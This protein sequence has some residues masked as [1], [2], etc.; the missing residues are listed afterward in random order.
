MIKFKLLNILLILLIFSELNSQLVKENLRDVVIT[1]SL[2]TIII[3]RAPGDWWFGPF[4]SFTPFTSLYFGKLRLPQFK[5]VEL[6]ELFKK[7]DYEGGSGW[8]YS[9][10]LY[11]EWKKLDQDFGAA[12]RISLIDLRTSKSQT[13][14]NDSVRT[15]FENKTEYSYLSV[16]PSAV[17]ELKKL[18]GFFA[19]GGFDFEIPLNAKTNQQK[20]FFYSEQI[21]EVYSM[22]LQSLNLRMGLHL[23]LSYDLF[24][25]NIQTLA[26]SQV[27]LYMLMN[28]GTN[29]ISNFGSNFNSFSVKMGVVIKIGP[30]RKFIDTL[31][32]NPD[33]EEPLFAMATGNYVGGINFQRSMQNFISSDLAYIEM[34]QIQTIVPVEPEIKPV[35]VVQVVPETKPTKQIVIG[36]R[37]RYNFPKSETDYEISKE[38]REYLDALAQFLI[39]N[40]NTRV[41]VEGH[42]DDRGGSVQENLR[43]S[44]LRAEQVKNYLM[45]KNIPGGRIIATGFGATRTLVPNNTAANRAK[46]RRVEIMVER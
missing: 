43:R 3:D 31:Y 17:Y 45:R 13:E 46:N 29:Q 12:L 16:S 38:L 15:I 24:S 27:S 32:F 44:V 1:N 19:F 21:D 26:R 37:E 11:G 7:I 8:G 20:R 9:A 28:T 10:G 6:Q 30:D 42:N 33:Y 36:K 25:A 14:L 22:N 40:P 18:S 34:P 2:D 5:E 39:S 4:A 35:E 41:I 23:G